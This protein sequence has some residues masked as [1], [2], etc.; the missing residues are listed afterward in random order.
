MNKMYNLMG[1]DVVSVVTVWIESKI[2][3]YD[4]KVEDLEGIIL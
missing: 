4:G 3:Q 1:M 2:S